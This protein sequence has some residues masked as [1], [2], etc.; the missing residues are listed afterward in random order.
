MVEDAR[1]EVPVLLV[2]WSSGGVWSDDAQ[3]YKKLHKIFAGN[4]IIAADNALECRHCQNA[5][6]EISLFFCGECFTRESP[7]DEVGDFV[8][9]DLR[10]FDDNMSQAIHIM[11]LDNSNSEVEEL[12][13]MRHLVTLNAILGCH[14]FTLVKG[15]DATLQVLQFQAEQEV[16]NRVL[17]GELLTTANETV[18]FGTNGFEIFITLRGII[19]RKHD[20]AFV[21][22]SILD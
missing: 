15:K 1:N 13:E 20:L 7:D 8:E 6:L 21:S 22:I 17:D 3:M 16:S 11:I 18:D 12:Q 9:K 14:K 2:T 4:F 5:L 19:D 10:L